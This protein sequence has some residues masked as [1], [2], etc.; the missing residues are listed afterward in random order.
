MENGRRYYSKY[1]RKDI[2][3]KK[4]KNDEEKKRKKP[5]RQKPMRKKGPYGVTPYFSTK[6]T[7]FNFI[8]D[9]ENSVEIQLIDKEKNKKIKQ[10]SNPQYSRKLKQ[11]HITDKKNKKQQGHR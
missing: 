4:K 2:Q 7:V 3:N 10:I 6:D 9:K 5:I 11:R 8:M 1:G